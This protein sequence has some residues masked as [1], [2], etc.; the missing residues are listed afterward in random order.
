MLLNMLQ[1]S[2]MRAPGTSALVLA[3][4]GEL[5]LLLEERVNDEA[6]EEE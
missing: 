5:G 2:E 1:N 6:W 3:F 4:F